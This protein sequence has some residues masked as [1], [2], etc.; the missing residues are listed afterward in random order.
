M[1]KQQDRYGRYINRRTVLATT[2][3]MMGLA[4]CTSGDSEDE[5]EETTT[6]GIPADDGTTQQ[7]T[8][9]AGSTE[10]GDGTDGT[11]DCQN[12]GA[13]PMLPG[14]FTRFEPG[15]SPL[16]V[17]FE[18]PGV[19]SDNL[20]YFTDREKVTGVKAR[21]NRCTE[22]NYDGDIGLGIDV[23]YPAREGTKDQAEKYYEQRKSIG[24][25]VFT[26]VD[27]FGET[28]EFLWNPDSWNENP[29]SMNTS[30]LI[31]YPRDSGASYHLTQI[32]GGIT[33]FDSDVDTVTDTC[34]GNIRTTV[35]MVIES[36]QTNPET[37][38]GQYVGS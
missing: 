25:E 2:A 9:P 4:G 13:C 24:A 14:S 15:E 23:Q 29:G 21:L 32:G 36:L 7:T 38:F 8:Q 34:A 27:L 22:S 26:T 37:T 17:S 6:A 5:T 33:L 35:K 1:P 28:V 11:G 20:D 30:A 16:L 18:Y 31:P 10:I 3:G 12:P 19:M